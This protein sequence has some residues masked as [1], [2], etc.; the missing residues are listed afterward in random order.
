[1]K[2][3]LKRAGGKSRLLKHIIHIIESSPHTCYCEVFAGGAA[4]LLSKTPATCEVL[5]D[6]DGDLVNFFLQAKFHPSALASELEN[7]PHSRYLFN[8]LK[9]DTGITE[10]QRAA[11]YFY[12]NTSSMFGKGENYAVAKTDG[13]TSI[14]NKLASLAPLSARLDRVSIERLDWQRC[15][16][17]YDSPETLFY[18]DPPY[19][20]GKC[21]QY[22]LF[23]MEDIHAIAVTLSKL[24]GKWL[25]SIN[26]TPEIR[27]LFEPFQ[28]QEI[29]TTASMRN[30]RSPGSTFKE[31][32][33]HPR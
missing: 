12:R 2:P 4:V 13:R 25:L 23:T 11:R 28:T 15:M 19:T 33:I 10:L 7:L 24:K 5:N 26:D 3:C 1:M 30:A 22:N 20:A 21:D 14:R 9:R 31:L 32:L 18:L 17:L 6:I 27:S 16:S 8:L 29:E